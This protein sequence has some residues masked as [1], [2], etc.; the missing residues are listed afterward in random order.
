MNRI[1]KNEQNTFESAVNSRS[2]HLSVRC[3]F[4][5]SH[6]EFFKNGTNLDSNDDIRDQ[7]VT[8]HLKT[9]DGTELYKQR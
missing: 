8:L 6:R 7:N 5:V 4:T 1:L 2:N 3:S 9:Y